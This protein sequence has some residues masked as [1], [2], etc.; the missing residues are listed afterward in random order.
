MTNAERDPPLGNPYAA[1]ATPSSE[2]RSPATPYRTSMLGKFGEATSL[3]IAHPFLFSAIV[4]T[5]WLPGNLVVNYFAYHVYSEEEILGLI[6][7]TMR[8]ELVFG[9]IYIAAMIH[10]LRELKSGNRPSYFESIRVG[11]RN[12]GRLFVAQFVAGLLI[13]LGLIALVI[14]GIVL[15]V[16]YAIIAPLVVLEGAS[17]T[18]ARKRSAELTVG[19]RWQV[20]WMAFLFFVG[21]LIL[22]FL[23]YLPLALV[24][25]LDSM[26]TAV[27]IDCFLDIIYAMLQI[28]LF[29][30]YWEATEDERRQAERSAFS[31]NVF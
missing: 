18:E 14:P 22:A 24:P 13:G 3:L 8:I 15:A 6:R 31:E 27:F 28:V 9:P 11:F 20:F 10:A 2:S 30:Y 5:V 16:R 17:A 23:V 29:L 26:A 7:S 21:M 19:M 25:Q 4:L 12:W 1:P